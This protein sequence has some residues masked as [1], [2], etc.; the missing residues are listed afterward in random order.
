MALPHVRLLLLVLLNQIFLHLRVQVL[1][2]LRLLLRFSPDCLFF[3]FLLR[4]AAL[5]LLRKLGL[6]LRNLGLASVPF[7]CKGCHGSLML[8]CLRLKLLLHLLSFCHNLFL[9]G[10][11][12]VSLGIEGVDCPLHLCNLGSKLCLLLTRAVQGLF[13]CALVS[14]RFGS[15]RGDLIL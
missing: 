12:R 6:E 9:L 1:D 10:G 11:E 7:G 14:Q 8:S 3:G 5:L 15:I 2:F 4:R 13:A